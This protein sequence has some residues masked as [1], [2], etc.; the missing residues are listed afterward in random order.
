VLGSVFPL[1]RLSYAGPGL[2]APNSVYPLFGIT[3]LNPAWARSVLEYRKLGR[4]GEKISVIG[5]GTWR[6]GTYSSPEELASQIEALRRG[7][8]LGVNL[9]DTAEMYGSGR[10][11]QA[12]GK[13]IDGMREDVFIA[14]KVS[15]GHLRYD[16]VIKACKGSLSRLGV[17]HIDLYQVHWPDPTVH[18]KE[19]MS[20]MEKLVEEGMIRYIGVSN[21][22]VEE[23][24]EARAALGRNEIVSNQVEYSLSS[25]YVE[26]EI[27]PYCEKTKVT[28]IAYSP[29]AQGAIS[30]SI[31]KR[32]LQKYKMT[33][34]QVMLNWVTRNQQVVAIPKATNL[35]HLEENVSSVSKRF[36]ASEYE[37]VSAA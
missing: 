37:Q 32:I 24:E 20:A 11:E 14:T 17:A 26:P 16:D 35:S 1:T 4:T 33:P 13:A 10:S 25:R 23:T 3:F 29:L 30:K 6:V 36:S 5:M 15:P 8:A 34:A 12:V 7:I 27:L 22:S 2:L 21:F 9:I 19:T 28:L 31:P 18:I